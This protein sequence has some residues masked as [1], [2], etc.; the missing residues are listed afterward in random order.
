M[1]KTLF[2]I[3]KTDIGFETHAYYGEDTE[4]MGIALSIATLMYK[5]RRLS[6]M[7]L[8]VAEDIMSNPAEIDKKIIT[9]KGG[10][11]WNNNQNK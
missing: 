4:R 1:E 6:A 2:E 10:V 5:D 7:I 3:I 11:P 9:V 8:S